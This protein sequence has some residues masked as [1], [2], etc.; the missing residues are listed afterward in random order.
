VLI[1]VDVGFSSAGYTIWEGGK[2]VTCG[3]VETERAKR[4]SVL[5]SNDYV[6]RCKKIAHALHLLIHQNKI[7]GL[8]AEAPGGSQNARAAAQLSMAMACVACVAQ[9][10]QI[11]DEWCT[12]HQVKRAVTGSHK[13]TKEAVMNIVSRKMGWAISSKEVSITKGKLAGTTQNRRTYSMGSMSWPEGK[14]EHIADSVGVYWALQEG[15]L[16]KLFG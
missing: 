10:L 14:F 8:I 9:M 1:S 12:P 2:L 11:P 6:T 15:N 3:L 7:Q 13:A 16:V 4:K 5:V